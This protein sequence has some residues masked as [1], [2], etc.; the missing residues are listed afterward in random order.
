MT[1]TIGPPPTGPSPQ[2]PGL[3]RRVVVAIIGVAVVA[4]AGLGIGLAVGTDRSS[5]N[6]GAATGYSYYQSMMGRFEIGSMMGSSNYGWMIGRSGYGWMMGG[7]TA[8]GWM[9]GGSLPGFMMGTKSDPGKVMGALFANAPGPRVSPAEAASLGRQA[10]SGTTVDRASNR[11]TF[12]S[13]SVRL[14]VLASPSMPAENFHIA[15]MVNPTV[16]VPI[17]AHVRIELV[18]TDSDMAHGLVVAANGP[19][20]SW[21]PMMTAAP[22]FPGA[23]LWFLGNATSA[24]MHEGTLAFTA[25]TPGSYQYLCPVPGHAQEGMAGAFDVSRTG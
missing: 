8:P 3:R 21:M 25:T 18:N 11:V 22:A 17:G 14:V 15:G 16:V 7:A 13:R 4:A 6:P 12:T 5:S 24:G 19:A 23:A 20:S 10:P 9:T 2:K 1:T